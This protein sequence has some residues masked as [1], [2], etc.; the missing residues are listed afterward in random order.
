MILNPHHITTRLID[1]SKTL[2]SATLALLQLSMKTP[3]NLFS[4][5]L[6]ALTMTFLL[7][8]L[9]RISPSRADAMHG[10]YV[11][12]A[13]K[14]FWQISALLYFRNSYVRRKYNCHH[15]YNHHHHHHEYHHITMFYSA[16]S[17]VM[18]WGYN[19]GVYA[20]TIW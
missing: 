9:P 18:W 12:W 11:Q 13:S 14:W 4:N 10:Q 2:K 5:G 3:T 19:C 17:H 15:H 1:L 8:P 16:T 20:T 6:K 7:H